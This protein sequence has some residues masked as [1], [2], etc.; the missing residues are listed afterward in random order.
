MFKS[1]DIS[2]KS[3]NVDFISE[4]EWVKKNKQGS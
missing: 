4:I 3:L 2:I 1:T